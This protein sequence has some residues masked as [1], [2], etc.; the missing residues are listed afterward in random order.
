MIFVALLTIFLGLSF[1]FNGSLRFMDRITTQTILSLGPTITFAIVVFIGIYTMDLLK[2]KQ[3][4]NNNKTKNLYNKVI[5]K[6]TIIG[7]TVIIVFG[8]LW[9]SFIASTF[10]PPREYPKI[11]IKA[12]G[13]IQ[14]ST[15]QIKQDGN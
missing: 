13:Q 7:I 10:S 2:T 5:K 3:P 4:T 8:I 1:S 9:S 15:T 12:D 14:P 6:S 11:Y